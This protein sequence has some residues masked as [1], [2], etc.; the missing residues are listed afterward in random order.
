MCL[1]SQQRRRVLDDLSEEQLQQW[2]RQIRTEEQKQ[3]IQQL[4]QQWAE[5]PLKDILTDA[6]N[7]QQLKQAEH[8]LQLKPWIYG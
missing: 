5:Q 1:R 7:T 6:L 8:Y 2:P 3:R 4:H